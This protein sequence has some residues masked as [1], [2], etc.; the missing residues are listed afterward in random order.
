MAIIAVALAVLGVPALAAAQAP[1]QGLHVASFHAPSSLEQGE[2][3]AISGRVSPAAAV[4]VAVERLEGD[5][6]R[7]LVTLTSSAK[8]RFSA[9]LPLA[10]SSNLR[11]S[12]HLADGTISS[13]RRRSVALRRRVSLAVT[14]APLE[15]I[16]GR[17]FTA[18]G[19][20]VASAPGE[21]V[22]LQG[23]VNG[24]AFRTIAKVAVRSGRVRAR[25]TPPS[26]GSWRFRIA[27]D[28]TPRRDA[29][30]SA[31]TPRMQV[32][33]S[34]PHGAPASA[35]DYLVQKISEFH[36]YYYQYGKLRRV[37]PVVF[38]K[39]STPTPVGRFSVYSK[40][41]GPSSAF[42]PLVLWYH[43]GYGIHG[44]N[45]EYLLAQTT[46]AFSH[47]CTRNYNANILWLWPRVPVG[48]PVINIP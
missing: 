39:P 3:A 44:T 9:R 22:A 26:G 41:A 28:A 45:E 43:R 34:N 24:H 16:S 23:S 18:T 46:R 30:G 21:K 11:V 6:W 38:G 25:F 2:R 14:A 42:G 37:F 15:N 5:S 47:G 36:L 17:P 32:Y 19:V 10:R 12:V 1:P 4:P 31:T 48:T 20:V 13:S 35:P 29:G 33:G 27:V 7:T 40:T 8:G